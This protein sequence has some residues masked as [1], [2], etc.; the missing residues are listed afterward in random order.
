[1]NLLGLFLT[2]FLA[3]CAVPAH[4]TENA[5]WTEFASKN[6]EFRISLPGEPIVYNDGVLRSV[7]VS[8]SSKDVSVRAVFGETPNLSLRIGSIRDSKA[9]EGF[10]SSKFAGK[11]FQGEVFILKKKVYRIAIYVG[12]N[13]GFYSVEAWARD[14]NNAVLADVLAS[15]TAR[16]TRIIDRAEGPPNAVRRVSVS[17]LQTSPKITEILSRKPTGS[18]KLQKGKVEIDQDVFYSQPIL[19][20]AKP[21]PRYDDLARQNN[22]QGTVVLQVQ[23]KADGEIGNIW[24][25]KGPAALHGVAVEAAKK[26]RFLPAEVD[27]VAVDAIR[28]VEYSFTIY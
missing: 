9:A 13:T 21:R 7:S 4:A 8:S 18:P 2:L 10:V 17:E 16:Q 27:G 3:A 1:M 14:S 6:G 25:L 22:V 28:E 5:E 26:I 15:I 19:F 23:F 11:D 12:T 24:A 20:L